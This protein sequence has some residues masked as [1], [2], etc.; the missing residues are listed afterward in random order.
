[1]STVAFIDSSAPLDDLLDRARHGETITLVSGGQP[2]AVLSPSDSSDA[3]DRS[4]AI[5]ELLAF[6][7]DRTL[8]GDTIRDL[9]EQGRR[10]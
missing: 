1:M 5:E 6:G 10:F 7:Q 3:A 9:M 4:A 8:C 2:L